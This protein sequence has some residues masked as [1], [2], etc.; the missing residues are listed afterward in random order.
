MSED[1]FEIE[2]KGEAREYTE[3]LSAEHR[4]Q[5]IKEENVK[6]KEQGLDALTVPRKMKEKK[7]KVTG[8]DTEEVSEREEDDGRRRRGTGK[9]KRDDEG[10]ELQYEG[11]ESF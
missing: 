3:R 11:R 8:S 10:P 1:D 5:K 4:R 2:A 7:R 9:R 6:R